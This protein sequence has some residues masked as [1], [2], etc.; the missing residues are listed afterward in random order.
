VQARPQRP[1]HVQPRVNAQPHARRLG[2]QPGGQVPGGVGEGVGRRV[3]VAQMNPW[4]PGA[5]GLHCPLGPRRVSEAVGQQRE[6]GE[7]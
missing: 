4:R 1:R 5:H 3:V 7:E 6:A 2:A